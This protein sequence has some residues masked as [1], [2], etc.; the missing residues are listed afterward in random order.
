MRRPSRR[1]HRGDAEGLLCAAAG[2]ASGG[3]PRRRREQ[4]AP[5]D[6]DLVVEHKELEFSHMR[7][8]FRRVLSGDAGSLFALGAENAL[9][10][11]AAQARQA[12]PG[13]ARRRQAVA[14]AEGRGL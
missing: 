11:L 9:L 3:G 1:C 10:T 14:C 13:G 12:A 5:F 2:P 7:D 6:A 4:I 8:Y